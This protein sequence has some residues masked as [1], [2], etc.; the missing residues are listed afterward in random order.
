MK[1]E[2]VCILGGTG[3]VGRALA[4]R[5]SPLGLRVRVV[6]R[7]ETH[8]APLLVLPTVEVKVADARDPAQ[9]PECFHDM[10]AVV[11]LVGILHEG[12]GQTFRAVHAEFPA[13]VARACQAA[14]VEHLLHMSALGAD[15][16]GPSAYQRTKGE[17][18]AA[19]RASGPLAWTIFR[20]SVIFG[21][22]DRF[23]NLFA[24]LSRVFP[25]IPLAGARVRF[26]PVWVEDVARAMATTLGR[27]AFHGAT[28]ELGGPTVYTLEELVRF[29]ARAVGRDP[30]ILPLPDG[31]ARLQAAVFE[32]LP[33]KLVTRDNLD[34]MRVDNVMTGPFPA[35]LGFAPA[36]MEAVVPEYLT[37]RGGR[38]RYARFRN[39][40]GR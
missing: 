40:A 35:A 37:A 18:E 34:S 28:L 6:T 15:P 8:A 36:A 11:N 5:L 14:G 16:A 39:L 12:G 33:G 7:R 31:L 30:A 32:R 22:D 9:L 38:A 21:E 20:P 2:S 29:A 10:Q 4:N 13:Q 26:Q 3:F 23:L 27:T 17:G 24:K 25:A 1:I 19:V